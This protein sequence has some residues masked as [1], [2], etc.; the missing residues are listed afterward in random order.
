MNKIK[1]SSLKYL[2]NRKCAIKTARVFKALPYLRDRWFLGFCV[3]YILNRCI[4]QPCIATSYPWIANC[5]RDILVVPCLCSVWLSSHLLLGIKPIRYPPT[6]LDLLISF[7]F[8]ST[9]LEFVFPFYFGVGVAD[10]Y[11]VLWYAIG[12]VL[13]IAVWWP[14]GKFG[15]RVIKS[16]HNS[17]S[18]QK[19][20]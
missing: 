8:F 4:V 7:I 17:I 6:S 16:E 9:L 20:P 5:F 12:T 11:D 15:E 13:G 10:F 2:K 19:K 1:A 14:H 3:F 18:H